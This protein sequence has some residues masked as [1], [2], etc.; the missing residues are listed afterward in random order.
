M[1]RPVQPLELSESQGQGVVTS[2][3]HQKGLNTAVYGFSPA[4]GFTGLYSKV[5]H[6]NLI[7]EVPY[8][9]Y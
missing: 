6:V 7:I 5:Y 4:T 8:A 9:S 2:Q 1:K 3:G